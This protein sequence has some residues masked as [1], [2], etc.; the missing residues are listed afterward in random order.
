MKTFVPLLAI[1]LALAPAQAAETYRIDPVHS[2][3]G[4]K[5]KHLYSK[6]TGRFAD[7]NGTISGDP[8]KPEE[9]QVNVEIKT[10]S[11]D[12]GDQKRD[13][14]LR[15]S[16]FFDVELFPTMK[17]V[18]R[19]VNRTG[20]DT[21]FVIGDLTMHGVT[22][23]CILQVTFQGKGKDAKG[24]IRTGWEARTALKRSDFGLTWG[25]AVEG[26]QVVSDDVEIEL[27]I[28]AVDETGIPSS[29][30]TSTGVPT[31]GPAAGIPPVAPPAT[32]GPVGV[33]APAAV[34]VPLPFVFLTPEQ[35]AEMPPAPEATVSAPVPTLAPTPTSESAAPA[36]V[37][38][39][40]PVA[41]AEPA[42]LPTPAPPVQVVPQVAPPAPIPAAAP[43][44]PSEA[45]VPVVPP[46]PTDAS[47]PTDTKPAVSADSASEQKQE[48][49]PAQ[50]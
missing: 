21:A 23:E 24:A 20:E 12:T 44:A 27:N 8:A 11:I 35:K 6:V 43:A 32:G 3:I 46:S 16:D 14:H 31:P 42:A 17:F 25:K 29:Q 30:L 9:A 4:F 19:K 7:V 41:P 28:E 45:A 40:P 47:A 36:P 5:I 15:S 38:A 49:T 26:T 50:D 1:S 34:Q 22:K 39:T 2:S 13:E 33:S 48:G 10:A 18:S 37:S